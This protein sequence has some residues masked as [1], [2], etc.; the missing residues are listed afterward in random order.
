MTIDHL[1][2][3]PRHVERP[4]IQRGTVV[5]P[6]SSPNDGM[7]VVAD[8]YSLDDPYEVP[9]TNWL[10]KAGRLP[11]PDDPCLIF[12]DDEGD[13]WVLVGSSPNA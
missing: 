4:D 1:D 6:P 8:N 10:S 2:G 11:D 9:G 3:Q 7:I 12:L 13:A 5:V